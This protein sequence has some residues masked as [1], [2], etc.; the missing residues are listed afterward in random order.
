M[1]TDRL[2]HIE[3]VTRRYGKYRP[4]GGGLGVV[5]GGLVL[6]ALGALLVQWTGTEYSARALPAQT[7][8]RF[9][10]DTRL[11]PPAW[12]QAAA[13]AAPFISWLGLLGI[14]AWVDRRFGA[15]TT[16]PQASRDR[17][18][19]PRWMAPFLV[20][21]L[22]ALLAGVTVWDAGTI[23][24]RGGVAILA[25][26][27]WALVWGRH[28]R[29]QLTMMVMLAVSVPSLYV[30][31]ATDP[32]ANFTAGSVIVFGSYFL[33]MLWLLVQGIIRFAGFLKVRAELAAMR[34]VDE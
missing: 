25:I 26:G 12:L 8:W 10:R 6:G 29:D 21:M 20:L 17:P 13:I 14:Q 3:D 5:W 7:L 33:L 15:V 22:A 16:A 1:D 4:C 11:D 32:D 27:A 23:A 34:P 24:T 31:A 18:R 30:M 19:G 2:A 28:S 9:L